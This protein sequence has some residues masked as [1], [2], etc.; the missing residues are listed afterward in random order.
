MVGKD[1]GQRREAAGL[2]MHDREHPRD[3][4]FGFVAPVQVEPFTFAGLGQICAIDA[5]NFDAGAGTPHTDDAVAGDRV[6]AVGQLI[7]DP[8]SQ[9]GN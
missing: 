7:R 5:V 8:G 3:G 1:R 4:A 6:A 9:A 2:I